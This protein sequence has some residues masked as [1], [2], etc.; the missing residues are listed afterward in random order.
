MEVLVFI[1]NRVDS[2]PERDRAVCEKRGMIIAVRPDG[3]G[4]GSMESKQR[5]IA[6]G[7]DAAAW[8]GQ[9]VFG[10]VKIPG[11]T[12]GVRI[13]LEREQ[14]EDDSGTP[15]FEEGSI[16][17]EVPVPKVFRVRRWRVLVDSVPSSIRNQILNN[18]EVTVTAT[19]VRNF[20]RRIRD[21][22]QYQDL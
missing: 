21:D 11:V 12:V 17:R 15:T 22:M 3:W 9:G 16:L 2:N 7:G 14:I 19:Q 8:P 13:E 1:G 4:W 20:V 10:I 5:W 6:E 18:G